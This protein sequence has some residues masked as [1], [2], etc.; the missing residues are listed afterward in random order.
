MEVNNR[1]IPNE[2]QIKGFFEPA[3]LWQEIT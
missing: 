2:E 3:P 1:V